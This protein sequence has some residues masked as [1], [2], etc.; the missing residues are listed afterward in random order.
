MAQADIDISFDDENRIRV[1]P[2]EKFKATQELD[3]QCKAF[4]DKIIAFG[5]TVTT[6]VELLDGEAKKIEY[7]KRRGIGQRNRK[8]KKGQAHQAEYDPFEM[9]AGMA[10]EKPHK[11][12]DMGDDAQQEEQADVDDPFEMLAGMAHGPFH[13]VNDMEDDAECA[14]QADVDDPFEMLAG[15]VAPKLR[16]SMKPRLW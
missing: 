3:E 16:W 15:M 6:L 4:T 8:R 12:T 10:E 13:R 11:D 5:G 2:K 1:M 9:L 7:E 14:V